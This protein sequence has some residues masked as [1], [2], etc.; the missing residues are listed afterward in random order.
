MN[1]GSAKFRVRLFIPALAASALAAGCAVGP[2]YRRPEPVKGA[3]LPSSF[4]E[5]AYGEWKQADPSA[6]LSRGP[7][8]KIY[9][10][11]GLDA[12]EDMAADGNTDIAVAAASLE[13]ARAISI[14]ARAALFPQINGSASANRSRSSGTYS[15][16][17]SAAHSRTSDAF[18]AEAQ[19]GWEV[20]L[21]GRVRRLREQGLASLSASEDDFAAT[22]LLVESEVAIDY[23]ALRSIDARA[24]LLSQT[25]EAYEKAL[26]LVQSRLSHG[27]ADELDLAQATTQLQAAKASLA[28][29]ELQRA[30]MRHALAI[31]CGRPAT[32]FSIPEPVEGFLPAAPEIPGALPSELLESRPDVAAAERRMASANAAVGVAKGAFFPKISLG[33]TGGYQSSDSSRLFDWPSH[34]WG[35]GPSLSLPIFTGGQNLANYRSSKAAYEASVAKYRAS[36]LGAIAE[37][38]DELAAQFYLASQYDSEQAALSSAKK[39]LEIAEARYK[40]GAGQYLDVIYAQT[41]EL[42]HEEAL[43]SLRSDRLAASVRLVKAVGAGWRPE[44][45]K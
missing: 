40:A 12:V 17:R 16:S 14:V 7:W 25:A 23:F 13:Q 42:S 39:T 43:L 26:D 31:L 36:V 8:W 6:A 1:M 10:D 29:T 5:A 18:S 4:G 34:V 15:N 37:V 30:Q 22:R 11:P 27:V 41:A 19:A 35:V 21:W 32:G 33:A 44:S 45:R 9:G 24:Q 38:E 2:N 20:D 3:A 28:A